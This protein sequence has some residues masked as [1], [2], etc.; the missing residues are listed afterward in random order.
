MINRRNVVTEVK[1]RVN[2]CKSFLELELNASIV[3][4]TMNL[5]EISDIDG[6]P[7]DDVLPLALDGVSCNRQ[8]IECCLE[9]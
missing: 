3:A 7:K 8:F 5:L 2:A 6:S 4:A 1:W 9:M